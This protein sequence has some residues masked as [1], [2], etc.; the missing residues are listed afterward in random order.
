[1]I[2]QTRP[3][4]ERRGTAQSQRH[5]RRRIKRSYLTGDT[6]FGGQQATGAAWDGVVSAG[7]LGCM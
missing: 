3:L 7:A 5:V 4:E 6:W 2:S 1:M